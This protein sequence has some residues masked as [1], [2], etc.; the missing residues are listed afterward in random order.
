MAIVASA[1]DP[2]VEINQDGIINLVNAACCSTFQYKEK[3]LLGQNVSILMP[4]PHSYLHDSYLKN[5]LTTGVKKVIGI[6]RKLRGL[7]LL[8]RLM[9]RVS[10]NLSTLPAAKS[11]NTSKVK[12]L[13]QYWS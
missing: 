6:G 13:V 10:Y 11:S 12:W 4:E 1:V 7:T 8:F 3:E 9:N 2:I 5:Y